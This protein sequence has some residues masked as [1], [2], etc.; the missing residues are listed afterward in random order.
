MA[1]FISVSTGAFGANAGGNIGQRQG[2]SHVRRPLRGIQVKPDTYATI[3]VVSAS[4]QDLL[5]LDSGSPS[6]ANGI[7]SS[8]R[9]SNFILQR[10]SESR[11]EKQQIVETFGEDYV[12]FFGEKPRSMNFQGVLV[13]TADFNW[14]AEWWQNYDRVFRGT[15]LVEENARFYFYYDDLVVEGYVLSAN[16]EK[17]ASNPNVVPFSFQLFV[18]NYIDLSTV[19]SVFFQQLA[20]SG[21]GAGIPGANPALPNVANSALPLSASGA[22]SLAAKTATKGATG[23]L[24]GFLASAA[25]YINNADFKIQNV[26]ETVRTTAFGESLVFPND[27]SSAVQLPK[28]DNLAQFPPAPVNQPIHTMLDEYVSGGDYKVT[29]DQAEI[30]RVSKELA[31][32]SPAAL[33]AKARA[34]LAKMGIDATRRST[35]YLL[36]GRAAFAGAQVF[37]SFGLRQ[38]DGALREGLGDLVGS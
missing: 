5:M 25:Q 21:N 16:A 29:L 10:V 30:A 6:I 23:G 31:L 27:L 17:E 11:I 24:N 3:R 2:T 38:A 37:G 18:T 1:V 9:Y 36:L 4:G 32:R 35:G 22:G 33:D 8:T 13:D 34:D 7:G 14:R 19:G 28:I 20:S 26:L 15:R 12:F